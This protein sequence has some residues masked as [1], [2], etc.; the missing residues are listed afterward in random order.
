MRVGSALPAAA[1]R[2]GTPHLA[3]RL[4]VGVAL[5][6][7][8]HQPYHARGS[9]SC[10]LEENDGFVF[11]PALVHLR[12]AARCECDVRIFKRH[13]GNTLL[14]RARIAAQHVQTWSVRDDLDRHRLALR[15]VM[16]NDVSGVVERELHDPLVVLIDLDGNL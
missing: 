1:P 5:L 7:K 4:Y 13:D 9:Y 11:S 16:F 10:L 12:I 14:N 8:L 3:S 15:L 2:P 6:L